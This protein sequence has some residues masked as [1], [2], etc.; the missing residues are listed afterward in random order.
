MR[1]LALNG[2][3]SAV[4]SLDNAATGRSVLA[5]ASVGADD[6]KKGRTATGRIV[7][8]ENVSLDL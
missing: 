2:Q 4:A 7:I 1:D 6:A 5:G 3:N 8:S